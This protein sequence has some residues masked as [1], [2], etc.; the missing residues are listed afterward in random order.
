MSPSTLLPDKE[1]EARSGYTASLANL[2]NG[3]L[4]HVLR[5]GDRLVSLAEQLIENEI[6]NLAELYMGIRTY[7]DGGKNL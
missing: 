1:I 6:S 4:F 5:A 3:L 7:F 2:P